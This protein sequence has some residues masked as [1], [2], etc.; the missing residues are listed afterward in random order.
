MNNTTVNPLLQ[1]LSSQTRQAEQ[2]QEQNSDELGK[3]VFLELLVTQMT[4]QNPLEPQANSEF[5]AQ[6]AQFSSVEGLDNLNDTVSDMAASFQSSQVLQATSLVGRSVSVQTSQASLA[7]EGSVTGEVNVPSGA[8]SLEMFVYDSSGNLV[9][10]KSITNQ[11]NPGQPLPVGT[12]EFNWSGNN[13][14]GERMP[15]GQYRIELIG[16]NGELSQSLDTVMNANVDSVTVGASGEVTL[17]V[18]GV[19]PVALSKLQE[20][21]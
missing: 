8:T 17:N 2:A 3:D 10:N 12:A 7:A 13:D 18:A 1:Q 15:E 20:I 16:K 19:G 4:N 11:D 14:A 6:L 21:L 5:V 9:R